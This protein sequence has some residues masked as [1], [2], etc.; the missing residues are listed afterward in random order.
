MNHKTDMREAL[1]LC[2]DAMLHDGVPT[3]P[4]HPRRVALAAAENALASRPD[5]QADERGAF[6]AWWLSDVPEEHRAFAKKL[7]DSYSTDYTSAAGVA[8][9]WAA[10]R[11]ARAAAPQAEAAQ[12]VPSA[13]LIGLW[14]YGKPGCVRYE[15]DFPRGDIPEGAPVYVG[16]VPSPDLEQAASP[17]RECGDRQRAASPERFIT[18]NLTA[19]ERADGRLMNLIVLAWEASARAAASAPTPTAPAQGEP[20]AWMHEKAETFVIGGWDKQPFAKDFVPLFRETPKAA[21]AVAQPL[22]EEQIKSARFGAS[23]LESQGWTAQAQAIR[24]LLESK[25]E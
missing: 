1:Q 13:K 8:D 4:Y 22:T 12:G 16:A 17:S 11:A 2:I 14:D 18:D 10:W 6:E 7:L 21:P 5:A 25:G 23:L 15:P 19:S 3:D 9:A 24:A 20:A